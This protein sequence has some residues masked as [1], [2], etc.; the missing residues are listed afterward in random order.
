MERVLLL[1]P[2]VWCFAGVQLNFNPGLGLPMLAAMLKGRYEVAVMDFEALRFDIPQ[3]FEVIKQNKPDIIGITATSVGFP[4]MVR[5]SRMVKSKLGTKVLIG[6]CHV[7]VDPEEAL[8][9]TGADVAVVGE[10]ESVIDLAIEKG[11]GVIRNRVLED[12]AK[13]PWPARETMIPSI[14]KGYIGN[15]PRYAMPETSVSWT[16]GCPHHCAFCSHAVFGNRPMKFRD[17]EDIVKELIHLKYARGINSIFVYDDELIGLS[18][19]QAQWLEEVLD[20][21]IHANLDLTFK[22]QVRCNKEVIK[23][24]TVEKMKEA[25]FKGL[26][27]GCESG[28]QK[29]LDANNK[30]TTPEDIEYTV[31]LIHDVGIET[32]TFWMV[33]NLE[34]TPEETE[35]TADLIRKLK[36]HITHKQ[37]TICTPWAGSKIHKLAVEGNWILNND[38][39]QFLADRP[40][41]KTPWMTPEEMEEGRNKLLRA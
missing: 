39:T 19:A 36:P 37:V 23:R 20:K 31:K 22:T 3:T 29:V 33:G 26:M 21:I 15:A 25:G 28:S 9:I 10:G 34:E 11:Y 4:G 24:H 38:P 32:F 41:M 8:K 7:S 30:G 14:E 5:I 27:I 2:P 1:N 40:Q 6:G 17:P 12:F 16:R 18:K 35:K 13:L